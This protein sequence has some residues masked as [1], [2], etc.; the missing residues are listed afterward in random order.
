MCV[1]PRR[2]AWIETL[3]RWVFLIARLVAPRRGAWIETLIGL[4]LF[5]V[6]GVAPRRGAWIETET[7][8][9]YTLVDSSR[10]PQGS[11]D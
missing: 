4:F 5:M 7:Y 11:V 3:L 2:G 6:I 1:A 9:I 10:S 8:T